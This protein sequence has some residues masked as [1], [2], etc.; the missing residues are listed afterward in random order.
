MDWTEDV[1]QVIVPNLKR[2]VDRRDKITARLIEYCISAEIWEADEH[3]KGYFGLLTTMKRIFRDCLDRGLERVLIFE[4]DC[5]FL[6][7]VDEFHAV[8]NKCCEDLKR[9]NWDL[10]YLGVQH[11]ANFSHW[12]TPNIL[13][14]RLGYSTHAV[15]YSRKVMEFFLER[16]FD[17]P[18]D[19][20]LQRE[21]QKY[22][23]SFC[24][25]P[26][27]CSQEEGYS[28][29][30][31]EFMSWKPFIEKSFAKFTHDIMSSRFKPNKK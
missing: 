4:D 23:T 11:P 20:F 26:L 3:E 6:V 17:E 5:E 18:I 29:I 25:F 22:N 19:N 8:M 21:F 16:H 13:P 9:M 27:L 15:L 28:D 2:R 14:V 7:G 12:V 24:A 30:G 1:P 10:F 31:N